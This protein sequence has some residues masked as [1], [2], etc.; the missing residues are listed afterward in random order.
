MF[1]VF[2][3]VTEQHNLWLVMLA[4]SACFPA[5]LMAVTL[6][7]RARGA[8]GAS[9]QAWIAI[10]GAAS[11]GGIWATHFI[12]MLAYEPGMGIA[13]DVVLTLCSLLVAVVGIIAGLA[14]AVYGRPT[15]W[16]IASAGMIVGLGVATMH[17]VGMT[18]VDL[19]GRV[20]WS[21]GLAL[22]AI[23]L[24]VLFSIISL[25]VAEPEN[26]IPVKLTAAGIL[27]LGVLILHFTAMAAVE[28]SPDPTRLINSASISRETLALLIACVATA[29]V[30][31]L[32]GALAG[33]RIRKQ[34]MRLQVAVNNMV[35][36]LLM[37]DDDER[38]VIVNQR[39]IH[40][41]G[42]SAD[43]V[44]PG[45]TF[46]ELLHH[47]V[48]AGQ[49]I[50]D[51]EQYRTKL[52][53]Q[54][55]KGTTVSWV[56]ETADGR[57]ISIINIP[58][59]DG[60]WVVT[61]EDISEQWL[62]E[63][64][65]EDAQRFLSTVIENAP[66]P[67]VV[68][69]PMT[70]QLILANRA[71]EQFIGA[72]HEELLGKTVH[73]IFPPHQAKIIAKFEEEVVQSGRQLTKSDIALEMPDS[74]LRF[75]TTTGFVVRD[76]NDRPKH[77]IMVIEDL[78]ERRQSEARIAHMAHHDALTDLPNR[79]LLHERL[80]QVLLQVPQGD[81]VA[82]LYLDLDH[83]KNVNDTLGHS[84]GDQLLKALANRLHHCVSA[85]DMVARLGGDE[86]AIIHMQQTGDATA[87]ADQIRGAITAP[88]DLDDHQV[89]VDVSIG[90]AVAQGETTSAEQLLQNADMA[91]YGAKADGRGT[92]RI[93]EP[94]MEVRLRARRALE[95]D[96]RNALANGEFQL[97]Y[98]PLVNLERQQISGFEALLRWN[99]S[100]RGVVLPTEFIPIAEEVGLICPIG[101]WVLKTACAEATTWPN[102][103][104]VAVNVSPLQFKSQTLGMVVTNALASSGLSARRLEIEITEAVLMQNDDA[105][106]STLH[107]LR[108]LGV[109]IALDDF[110][111]G[112]SSLSYLRSFPFDKIK[113]DRSFVNDLSEA[114][115]SSAIVFAITSLANSL[116]MATTV[117]GVETL[118][119]FAKIRTVGC[120]E[121]QGYLFS[122]PLPST[123]L[124]QFFPP[125]IWDDSAVG[126]A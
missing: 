34:E 107:Q 115:D 7:H 70:Q 2:G 100:K 98:Q 48:A 78:T 58:M 43:I 35:Q 125:R 17:F 124:R 52:I 103:I 110:G 54:L 37:F 65:L 66:V 90:I 5:C 50:Q 33:G 97:Y 108:A 6:F 102:A 53:S 106:M 81:A 19:P 36:G 51:A 112:Y 22:A 123:E 99:H 122:P 26:S 15:R 20:H 94:D 116:N 28:F 9:R 13:Y 93:F 71:Y 44:K 21:T 88:F 32:S 119:Q 89:L 77:L 57:R 114:G 1:R 72:P 11:G 49:L 3:C 95:L 109:R 126:A 42:L 67:I 104:S 8:Y 101:E 117:E 12:A 113:I 111:T 68:K 59:P 41:Y 105:T 79:V 92:F 10:A 14:L 62:A 45:C 25:F 56:G 84:V 40:M 46:R 83:F 118:A 63:R 82:L 73:D 24:G 121:M 31:C 69:E 27:A 76:I 47:R 18:A 61:H 29:A 60:G 38:I 87:L 86:F 91:L 80:N 64:K 74:V 30:S 55:T 96:L 16:N 75:I 23:G 85:G 39:Y 120:N 4:A